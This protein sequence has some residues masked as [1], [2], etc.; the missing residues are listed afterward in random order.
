M[1][2]KKSSWCIVSDAR[3]GAGLGIRSVVL[4]DRTKEQNMWWTS[5][6]DTVVMVYRELEAA[7]R[8]LQRFKHNNP[9]LM[10]APTA[11]RMLRSQREAMAWSHIERKAESSK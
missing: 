2:V 3:S 10:H 11:R 5:D 6:D 9:R 7:E 1:S 8:S 4:V